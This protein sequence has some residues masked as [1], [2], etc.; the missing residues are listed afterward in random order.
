M[1]EINVNFIFQQINH[2]F[3]VA[4][5]IKNAGNVLFRQELYKS[6]NLKY[7]KALRYLNKLHESDIGPETEQRL[8]TLEIPCLL[9]R[10]W[11]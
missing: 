6:A 4:E 9:N 11:C 10:Y 2:V 7:E 1:F 3:P 5:M 8:V